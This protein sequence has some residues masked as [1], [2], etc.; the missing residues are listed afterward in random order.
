MKIPGTLTRIGVNTQDDFMIEISLI[1]GPTEE[2]RT[3]R[4]FAFY[5]DLDEDE[6]RDFAARLVRMADDISRQKRENAG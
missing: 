3:T 2:G 4:C 1:V 6:A 5:A